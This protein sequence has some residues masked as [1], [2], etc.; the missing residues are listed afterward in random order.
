MDLALGEAVLDIWRPLTLCKIEI[1]GPHQPKSKASDHSLL[2]TGRECGMISLP[3][4]L[5]PQMRQDLRQEGC[6]VW[7][8]KIWVQSQ[9]RH[10]SAVWASAQV[11]ESPGEVVMTVP[12]VPNLQGYC[13]ALL[14]GWRMW[15][16]PVLHLRGPRGEGRKDCCD[17][18]GT[19]IWV[20]SQGKHVG[21]LKATRHSLSQPGGIAVTLVLT[22]LHWP[23]FICG[24]LQTR[25]AGHCCSPSCQEP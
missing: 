3:E 9:L 5:L 23:F 10:F 12:V 22:S 19:W 25:G 14:T 2:V 11:P 24:L 18:C 16:A 21:M 17:W 20:L 1:P 4:T 13:G 6:E 15:E 8:P 7:N